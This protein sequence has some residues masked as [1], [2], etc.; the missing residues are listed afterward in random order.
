MDE[1]EDIAREM[2]RHEN[3]L[4]NHRLTWLLT[5]EGLLF[6][7]LGFAWGKD[8]SPSA[9]GLVYVFCGIGAFVPVLTLFILDAAQKALIRLRDWWEDA[10]P[11]DYKGPGIIGYWHKP[12]L[13][14]WFV[15]WRILPATFVV[16][17]LFVACFNHARP[18]VNPAVGFDEIHVLERTPILSMDELS[19]IRFDAALEPN[20]SPGTIGYTLYNPF[21]DKIIRGIV[22]TVHPRGTAINQSPNMDLFIDVSC[23]PLQCVNNQQ[24]FGPLAEVA[25]NSNVIDL[26]EVHYQPQ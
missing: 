12:A 24:T 23:G 20:Y 21:R 22:V 15:P 11:P 18:G 1:Y 9:K 4:M 5:L 25:K 17:W 10:R 7:A 14:A 8:D 26:K 13:I 16:A 19:Q 2:V 6:A 3:E